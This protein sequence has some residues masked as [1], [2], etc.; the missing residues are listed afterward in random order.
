MSTDEETGMRAWGLP[1]ILVVILGLA[2]AVITIAGMRAASGI[3]APTFL[4]L[5]VTIAAHPLRRYLSGRIPSW[6]ATVIC[7]LVVYLVVIGLAIAL[8]ASVARLAT[9]LPQYESQFKDLMSD[10]TTWLRH[11]GVSSK[12]LD[13]LASSLDLSRL[14]SVVT[15]VVHSVFG[16][17]SNLAFIVTLIFFMTIDASTFPRH[18][19]AAA[20]S[21][22]YLVRALSDFAH[23]TRHYLVV[24]TVFGLIVAVLD[25]IGLL[26][27]GIPAA[28]L[29]GLL[30]FLTNYIPNI[31]FVIG[32]VPPA[33]LALLEGGPGLMI[34]VIVVYCVLNLVIQSFIQPKVVGDAVG[35]SGTLTFMSLVFWTWV[36]GPL[37]AILAVPMS[38]LVRE[39]LVDADTDGRWLQPLVANRAQTDVAPQSTRRTATAP[40]SS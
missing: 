33:V 16:M 38:L 7:M 2:A 24:S 30:A 1:R 11:L 8:I 35:L 14:S 13:N 36:L 21:H 6:A 37:G 40:E 18:L 20:S 32:L 3:L 28:A 12:Q 5:V 39:L 34:A 23:V 19:E 22:P 25:T 29:W 15:D 27:L 4:A 9:L 17:L 31:G 10:A 26:I